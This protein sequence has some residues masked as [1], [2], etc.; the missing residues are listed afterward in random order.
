[1]KLFLTFVFLLNGNISS[2][3]EVKDG[4]KYFEILKQTK[5]KDLLSPS[6]VIVY[7]NVPTKIIKINNKKSN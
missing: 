6:N 3:C 5:K 1:M 4:D 7:K 2:P